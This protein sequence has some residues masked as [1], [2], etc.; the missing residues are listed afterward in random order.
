[1]R[2]VTAEFFARAL[3]RR[4]GRAAR[5]L[6]RPAGPPHPPDGAGGRGAGHYEPIAWDDALRLIADRAAAR[7]PRPDEA[8]FYTSGRTSNEAAFALPAVGPR[9]SA[10][11]TCRTAPTCATSRRGVGA[12]PRPSASARARSPL[13]DLHQADLIVVVGQNPGT[14]HPR[15]LSAL[16]KAKR[17]GAAI[18]AVNPL[19]EAGLMRFKQP[20]DGARGGRWGH[21]ARPTSSCRSGSAATWRCSRRSK[22]AAVRGRGRGRPARSSTDASSTGIARLRRVRPAPTLDR[23][24]SRRATGLDADRTIEAV[25]ATA[26]PNVTGRR[27]VLLGDGPD[28]AA[29]LGGRPSAR[30]ST[31]MLLRGHDRPARR[32]AVPG[33]RP[34]QRAGRPH[35]GHLREGARSRIPGR[36]GRRGSGSA[37]PREHGVDTVDAIRAMRDGAARRVLRTGRQLR[38]RPRPDTDG[39]RGARCAAAR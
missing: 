24:R 33:A 37:A 5:L 16:E 12:R 6:A 15:M 18:I 27:I 26:S 11:T 34:Q 25:G 3:G 19:P 7:W 29:T 2:R 4:A 23:T 21:R 36:A 32:R 38:P 10:P 22:R 28:P 20:A 17:N 31:C 8:L 13:D 14:N 39:H 1:M 9:P 35:H 30:S